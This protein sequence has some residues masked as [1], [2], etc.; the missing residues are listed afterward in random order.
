MT[1]TK[2]FLGLNEDGTPHYHYESDMPVVITGKAYG[3]MTTS[4]GTE[5]DIS[6]NVIEVASLEH[7]GELSHL[8]G[9]HHEENGHPDHQPGDP[10]VHLCSDAC[11]AL[12]RE[13]VTGVDES[14][15]HPVMLR[16]GTNPS[17]HTVEG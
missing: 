12:K 17:T 3:V 16:N 14:T 6:D 4:D 2:T 15:G 7:A 1:M 8:I 9:V 11:G 5:Y 10:F 13:G